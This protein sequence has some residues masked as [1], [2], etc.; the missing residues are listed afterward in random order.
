MAVV[1]VLFVRRFRNSA[2]RPFR[3]LLFSFMASSAF[4]PI[5]YACFLNGYRQMDIQAGASRYAVTVLLYLTAVTI[6]GVSKEALK[7]LLM[8]TAEQTRVPEA[9]RPGRFDLWGHS[10]QV[11]HVLMAIG[12]TVHFSA[13]AKAFDYYH[14]VNQC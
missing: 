1:F 6:Y 3:G 9:W 5:I 8:L 7:C 11:F 4:Y 12:L 14:R 13:F 2:W 10:H